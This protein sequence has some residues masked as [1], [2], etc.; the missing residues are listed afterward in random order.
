MTA[1]MD[2][3]P[4]GLSNK[5]ISGDYYLEKWE[6]GTTFY[7]HDKKKEYN[8]FPVETGPGPI[9][10]IV[11]EMGWS[12]NFIVALRY[13]HFRGDKDGWMII[14]VKKK[15]VTGPFTDTEIEKTLSSQKIKPIPAG[16]AW[17][18]L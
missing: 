11:I 4:F 12:K 13:A 2:Q 7:L 6:D 8:D 9:G 1:C 5:T 10:G 14:D 18:E 3:D 17:E 16:Q 15:T